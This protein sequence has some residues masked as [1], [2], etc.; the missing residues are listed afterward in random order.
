ML[1]YIQY[2]P[3]NALADYIECYWICRA[4]FMAMSPLERLIPGGRTEM[5]LSFGHPMQFLIDDDSSNDLAVTHAQIMG[6]RNRIYYAKQTGDTDLLGVRFKPGGISAFT[7]LPVSD[8]L[9]QIIPAE[10]VRYPHQ[11]LGGQVSR[12]EK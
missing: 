10:D 9:N 7:S 3:A 1:S 5:I 12:R 11:R 6:Q 8:L 4:P 2:K